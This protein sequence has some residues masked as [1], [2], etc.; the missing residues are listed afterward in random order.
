MF[1]GN[2]IKDVIGFI[3]QL[4]LGQFNFCILPFIFHIV[5]LVMCDKSGAFDTFLLQSRWCPYYY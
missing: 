4:S 2:Y 1:K 5:A 3:L